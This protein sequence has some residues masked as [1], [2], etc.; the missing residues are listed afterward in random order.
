MLKHF[1]S[2]VKER[3]FETITEV[4]W[5]WQDPKEFRLLKAHG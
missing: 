3:E 2:G 1:L 4:Q 5:F